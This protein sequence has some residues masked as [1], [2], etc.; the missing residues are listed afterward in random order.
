[1]RLVRPIFYL[2]FETYLCGQSIRIVMISNSDFAHLLK[3]RY[4]W[5]VF[6]FVAKSGF[7]HL[8]SKRICV[9]ILLELR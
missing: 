6:L 9:A 7:V 1:M 3:F 2:I 5:Q 8:F 4:V